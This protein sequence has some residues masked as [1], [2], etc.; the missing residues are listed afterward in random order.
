VI[1]AWLER[2]VTRS[3]AGGES[4]GLTAKIASGCITMQNAV[5]NRDNQGR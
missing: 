1:P 2:E 5:H 4:A 3:V